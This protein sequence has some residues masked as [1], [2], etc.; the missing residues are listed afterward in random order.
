[1]GIRNLLLAVLVVLPAALAAAPRPP[2]LVSSSWLAKHIDDP[3]LVLLHVGKKEDFAA[4]HLPG[5]R[6]VSLA[7]VS[8]SGTSANGL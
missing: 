3:S 4:R 8:V 7:D 5:A 2:L 6:Y 1:M